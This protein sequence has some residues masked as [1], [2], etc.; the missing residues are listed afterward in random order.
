MRTKEDKINT[1]LKKKLRSFRGWSFKLK[2][3]HF[4]ETNTIILKHGVI[5]LEE[6]FFKYI[7]NILFYPSINEMV[8]TFK[9][10]FFL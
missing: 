3:S 5:I 6:S 9:E 2:T 10:E 8:I 1:F 7:E 4:D